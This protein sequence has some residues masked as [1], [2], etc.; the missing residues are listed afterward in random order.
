MAWGGIDLGGTKIEARLFDWKMQ[1]LARH[2]VATPADSY[3][4][5]LEGIYQQIQW[6]SDQ[7]EDALQAIGLGAPGLLN[8]TTGLALT[9]NLPASG[10]PFAKDINDRAQTVIPNRAVHVLNDC[11]AA[12]LSEAKYGPGKNYRSVVCL[13]IGTGV[14]GG[15]AINGHLIPDH[16]GQNCEFGHLPLP[17]QFIAEYDLPLLDCGCGLTGCFETYL[18]GP[19]LSRLALHVRN[20]KVSAKEIMN[21]ESF[22]DLKVIWLKLLASLVGVITRTSDPDLL[23]LGGGVGMTKGLPE[24]LT[25]HLRPHLLN[26]TE[27]PEI[28]QARFGDAS[29][30]FGAALYAQQMEMG[31]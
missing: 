12:T 15:H 17:A 27:P 30:A 8:P 4:A 28:A 14:A 24:Q 1:E 3:E 31:I 23:I 9:A 16:N 20:E 26:Q 7:S 29:C 19:G 6:L 13:A 22:S 2:R 5:L 11:R 21:D 10:H 18:S 25:E